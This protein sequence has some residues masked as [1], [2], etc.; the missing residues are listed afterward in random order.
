MNVYIFS[1]PINIFKI[2]SKSSHDI[3]SVLSS[4]TFLWHK[5]AIFSQFDLT[6]F[7][8]CELFSGHVSKQKIHVTVRKQR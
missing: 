6:H 8:E 5:S 2:L 1:S 7:K 3:K 4:L